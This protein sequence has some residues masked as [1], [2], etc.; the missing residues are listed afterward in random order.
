MGNPFWKPLRFELANSLQVIDA[1]LRLHNF[2]IDCR[3]ES[4][5][6]TELDD[7]ERGVFND[8]TRRFSSVHPGFSCGV[9]G[10]HEEDALNADETHEGCLPLW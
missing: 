5:Q 2:I 4:K 10:A 6:T 8:D 3:E 7:L 9:Q 1:C